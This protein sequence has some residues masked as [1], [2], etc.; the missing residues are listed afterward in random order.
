[1]NNS[2]NKQILLATV[3]VLVA[4]ISRIINSEFHMWNF[5]CVGAISLFSG[6]VIKD[7]RFAFIVPLAAYFISDV[8]LQMFYGTG[9]YGVSQLFVYGAM[10][11][12]VALGATMKTQNAGSVF[13]YSIG[14]SLLF[15]VVSNF[16]VW[17]SSAVAPQGL[18]FYPATMEG[19]MS[20]FIA[21]IPFYK[22][23]LA[24]DLIFSSVIF[25]AYQAI[26]MYSKRFVTSAN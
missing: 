21:G 18:Q 2:K 23:T 9:F 20:C 25:G 4:V 16:G 12:I 22:T 14:S 26:Q 3:L 13:G 19:L 17:A 24:G 11:M 8:Y 6:A 15:F 5:A 10:A 7:K 1:M